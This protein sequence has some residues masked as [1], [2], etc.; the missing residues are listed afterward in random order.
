[1]HIL[2]RIDVSAVTAQDVLCCLGIRKNALTQLYS[3]HIHDT[4]N[5]LLCQALYVYIVILYN[6]MRLY[7]PF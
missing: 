7:T 2:R 4:I 1:M 5:D 3:K 6:F